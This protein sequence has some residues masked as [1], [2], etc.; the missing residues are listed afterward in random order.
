MIWQ[1]RCKQFLLLTSLCLLNACGQR[2]EAPG[3]GDQQDPA[4]SG[5]GRLLVTVAERS[6]RR[7]V[8]LVERSTGN[9]LPLKGLNWGMPHRSP[10][11]SWNGR[12][13]A[14]ILQRGERSEIVVFDRALARL[15]PL[16][17]PGERSPQALTISPDGKR[18]GVQLL[19]RGQQDVELFN[20]PSHEPDLPP[21][22]PLR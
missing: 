2:F 4:L 9:E 3:I 18:L 11:L 16:P 13:L 15:R 7:A 14:F 5:N 1:V 6:G 10:S 17:F 21:G 22:A 12:Y 20:L 8:R 19:H